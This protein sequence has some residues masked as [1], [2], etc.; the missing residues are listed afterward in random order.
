MKKTGY[1]NIMKTIYL[2]DYSAPLYKIPKAELEISLDEKESIVKSKLY[3][4]KN[5]TGKQKPLSLNGEHLKL[6]SIKKDGTLLKKNQYQLTESELIIPCE[7]PT[8]ILEIETRIY[9]E[10]NLAL[11]GIYKSDTIICSQ[12]E[13]EGFRRITYFIDRPDNMCHFTTTLIANKTKFPTLLSNGNPSKRKNLPNN[14][15]SITWDDPFPKPSYLFAVVAGDLGKISDTFTT[16]SGRKIKLEIYVDKGNE[17]RAK[18]AM[19]ALKNS[20]KWDE[21]NYGREYDLD[22]F[23]IVAVDAFNMG[24]MENKGLNIFNAQYILADP[25]TATDA[26]YK[27]IEAV[28]AHEYFHNWTGN[29]ITCRDWFQLTLKEGLTVFRD[30]E[31]SSDMNV[32][33]IERIENVRQLKNIQFPE[34]ASPM[35]H[36]IKPSSYIE[37]NNFYTSTVYEKGSEIIRMIHTILG[38]KAFRKGTDLYFKTFDGQAVTT[39]DFIWA[40]EKASNIDLTQF[41]RWYNQAGTPEITVTSKY[42]KTKKE[43]RLAFKQDCRPTPETKTKKPFLFPIMLGLLAPNGKEIVSKTL[44]ISQKTQAFTFNNLEEKP[45]PSLLRN[46]SAPIKLHY[47]YSDEELQLLMTKDSDL[48]NRYEASQRLTMGLI[49][50]LL[51]SKSDIIIPKSYLKAFGACIDDSRLDIALKAELLTFPS[52]ASIIDSLEIADYPNV[53]KIRDK[54]ISEVTSTHASSLYKIYQSLH[55]SPKE[56]DPKTMAERRLKNTLLLLLSHQGCEYTDLA[57]DQFKKAEN[58]TDQLAAL[59]AL[60]QHVSNEANDA[61]AKFYKQW[62]HDALIMNKWFAVQTSSKR[63]DVYQT[64]KSLETN[65]A[66]DKKNPNKLRALYGSFAGNPYHFHHASGKGYHL[67]AE[68]IKS[69]D[70]YNPSIAARLANAFKIFPKLP[71]SLKNHASKELLELKAINKLSKNTREVIEKILHP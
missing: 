18:F 31:F 37:I 24:A 65:P 2:K 68:K 62:K 38:P 14:I 1:D 26:D 33:V 48:F 23:M 60:N 19:S 61:L 3:I 36:P 20:M 41:K 22:I 56:I 53:I 6:I 59:N 63:P 16:K 30:Q 35:S 57:Y 49:H 34:D 58:M 4:E 21:D 46:F 54:I 9:P 47:D 13:P 27:N 51:K 32:R 44:T 40:M 45:I 66:F 43:Y 71:D 11:E 5:H 67:L 70:T 52:T 8:C 64:L 15:Q 7:T 55:P 39:E 17:N 28:V 69:I 10:K 42:N 12:N 50:K 25:K 29:R